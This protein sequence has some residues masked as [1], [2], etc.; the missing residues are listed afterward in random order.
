M[1]NIFS[2]DVPSHVTHLYLGL[3]I[4]LMISEPDWLLS[5]LVG[6][7]HIRPDKSLFIISITH[8]YP[9]RARRAF[10]SV[11]LSALHC[12]HT[13]GTR[14]FPESHL[15]LL[16]LSPAGTNTPKPQKTR[17]MKRNDFSKS[18]LEMVN[19]IVYTCYL[20]GESLLDIL[21]YHLYNL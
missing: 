9:M 7:E 2:I 15:L 19:Y 14:P 11:C 12:E 1:G 6:G 18:E 16:F 10:I 3:P 13:T 8:V 4:Q 5:I 21:F 17:L 20:H